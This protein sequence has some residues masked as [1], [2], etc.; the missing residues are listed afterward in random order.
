MSLPT[1][2]VPYAEFV[3]R[4]QNS[5]D[6]PREEV[7]ADTKPGPVTRDH[8]IFAY[9]LF[10][11]RDPESEEVI[12]AG[13]LV[14]DI[15][16]LRRGFIN[17]PEFRHI[18]DVLQRSSSVPENLANAGPIG[19]Q[20]PSIAAPPPVAAQTRFEDGSFERDVKIGDKVFRVASDDAYLEGMSAEFEP[21]MVEIFTRLVKPDFQ[22]LDIGANI[23]L[24]SLLFGG[25]AS[26]VRAFEPSPTTFN[27]L[28]RNIRAAGLENVQLNNFGL[29]K[30]SRRFEL[31]SA[32][33]NRSGA[34]VSDITRLSDGYRVE[35]IEIK[36]GDE[37]FSH[38]TK[39]DRI[40]FIKIDVEGYEQN[41][42]EGLKRT[43]KA[44]R[45]VVVLELNHWCLN[46]FQR[47]SVP[48]F[49]DFL[50]RIFPYVFALHGR[51]V[52]DIRKPSERYEVMYEHILSL[53]YNNLIAAFDV[54][55]LQ[56]LEDLV[57]L[58]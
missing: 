51:S 46:A 2:P 45:P 10:L 7:L 29:G 39:C 40:H 8:V 25:L 35:K 32:P 42:I 12:R 33:G 28:S 44:S 19:T 47:I 16:T 3:V 54:K 37:F 26:S 58:T 34:F 21:D 52:K 23:G 11:G 50:L 5:S 55:Q 22:V 38:F 31:T 36:R 14:P 53:K 4:L 17:S 49:F 1:D 41:V 13:T 43:I 48:D 27:F 9:Q 6:L 24:T 30:Q 56:S 57:K 18:A 20:T 15:N